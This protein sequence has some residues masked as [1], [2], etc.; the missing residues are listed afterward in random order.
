MGRSHRDAQAAVTAVS[1]P[2]WLRAGP[3][4]AGCRRRCYRSPRTSSPTRAGSR[5]VF[6]SRPAESSHF[7]QSHTPGRPITG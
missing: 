1:R 3:M 4:A 2:G 5:P 6:S 7:A